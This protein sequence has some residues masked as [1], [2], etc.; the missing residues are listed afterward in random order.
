MVQS[1]W[2][3]CRS[4]RRKTIFRKWIF[5]LITV[6]VKDFSAQHNIAESTIWR[7]FKAGKFYSQYATQLEEHGE[8]VIPAEK[9]DMSEE[10][11]FLVGKV[12]NG[13]Y[14]RTKDLFS[15]VQAGQLGRTELRDSYRIEHPYMPSGAKVQD[16]DYEAQKA[17]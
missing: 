1:I 8:E 9:L 16:N 5:Q 17:A 14:D 10:N 11:L 12:G 4:S 7:N 13:D 6:Y 15:R 2:I 3:A